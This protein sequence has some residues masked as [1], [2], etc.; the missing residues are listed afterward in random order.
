MMQ[1]MDLWMKMRGYLEHC[2]FND[3]GTGDTLS[4][5]WKK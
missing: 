4:V 1:F 2:N 5:P 3:G